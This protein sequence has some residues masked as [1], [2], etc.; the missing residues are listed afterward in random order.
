MRTYGL[1]LLVGVF[2]VVIAVH[3]VGP[4]LLV[5]VSSAIGTAVIILAIVVFAAAWRK[6]NVQVSNDE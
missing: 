3:V 6:K 1:T 4:V 2:S 5:F